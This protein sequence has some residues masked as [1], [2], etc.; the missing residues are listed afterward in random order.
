MGHGREGIAGSSAYYKPKKG[1]LLVAWDHCS[2]CRHIHC[3]VFGLCRREIY[4]DSEALHNCWRSGIEF[5][6]P[7]RELFRPREFRLFAKVVKEV[8]SVERMKMK[9]TNMFLSSTGTKGSWLSW[10]GQTRVLRQAT[11]EFTSNCKTQRIRKHGLSTVHHKKVRLKCEKKKSGS[12]LTR[13]RLSGGMR[14][15]PLVQS[16][17]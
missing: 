13:H 4:L 14:P 9:S 15:Y 3:S 2:H 1:C 11:L 17:A 5:G 8:K 10:G 6:R 7:T 12:P 16:F